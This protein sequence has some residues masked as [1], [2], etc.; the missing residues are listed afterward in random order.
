MR[1]GTLELHRY[2]T[3]SPQRQRRSV[4]QY[5]IVKREVAA[6][7]TAGIDPTNVAKAPTAT[8][9]IVFL[10]QLGHQLPRRQHGRY[11]SKTSDSGHEGGQSARLKR[12]ISRLLRGSK[13]QSYSITSSAVASKDGGIFRLSAAAV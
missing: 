5:K 9:P 10:R 8:L 6:I 2:F 3:A 7:V 4:E 11:G 13:L 1:T 12:A